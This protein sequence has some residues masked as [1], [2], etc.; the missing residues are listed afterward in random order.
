MIFISDSLNV[1]NL[2]RSVASK[3]VSSWKLV[4][5][6]F[7]WSS[8]NT[9]STTFHFARKILVIRMS[10]LTSQEISTHERTI[11]T[12]FEQ[13]PRWVVLH[14]TKYLALLGQL[15]SFCKDFIFPSHESTSCIT[16]V[17]GPS[18]EFARIETVR[19]CIN[20]C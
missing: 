1:G 16:D 9:Q 19:G 6:V 17:L 18:V 13:I 14:R 10:L 5:F 15:G 8:V 7:R 20:F 3:Q 2:L 11:V 12:C 4:T